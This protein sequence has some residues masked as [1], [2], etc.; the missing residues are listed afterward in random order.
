MSELYDYQKR[1]VDA[2][3][4][5]APTLCAGHCAMCGAETIGTLDGMGHLMCND[6]KEEVLNA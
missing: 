3:R 5:S 6:C 2:L 1:G 4:R